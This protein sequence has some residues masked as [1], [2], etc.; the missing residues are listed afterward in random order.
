M[1]QILLT[2]ATGYVGGRLLPV[3]LERGHAVRCL[4]RSPDRASLPDGAEAVRGDVLDEGT[5]AGA[6]DG[7]EVAFYMVHSMEGSGDFAERDRRGA[8]NFARAAKA[9]GV[10]RVVYL[11]GLAGDSKHLRSREE[12]AELLAAE[13]P[14]LVHVRAAMIVGAGSASFT[15]LRS[16]VERLPV[17]VTPK[18]VETRTQ[19]VA[20]RD[21]VRVLAELAEREDAPDE[22]EVGGADVLTYGEMMRRFA[23]VAGRREPRFVRVP[24]L[25]PKLS[26]Y[27][28]G[29]VT[30]VDPALARPLV[31]GLS[32][33][34]L[35]RNAPPPGLNDEPL[36]FDDAVREALRS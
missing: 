18:W 24:V 28:V 15:M 11:G 32:A 2:G 16:L 22:V 9:A 23:R 14:P 20:V 12:V 25:T 33:E 10:R 30:P 35:V 5:L 1:T 34:M 19:P 21:V 13:G 4:T 3:L 36:G 27:W 31:E 26:S 8:R 29:F 6:F 7:I 17:M